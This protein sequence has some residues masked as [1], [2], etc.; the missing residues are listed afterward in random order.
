MKYHEARI[1]LL[2]AL[3]RLRDKTCDAAFT[4]R[5][6]AL[7]Y[8][9]ANNM[10][11]SFVDEGEPMLH[12]LRKRVRDTPDLAGIQQTI[13]DRLLAA[14]EEQWIPASEDQSRT[15]RDLLRYREIEILGHIAHGLST[16]KQ[17]LPQRTNSST[18]C[19]NEAWEMRLLVS[20]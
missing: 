10:I 2:C 5:E 17:P 14:F 4:A 1:S 18:R 19:L 7:R 12:L 16:L 8:A 20:Q 9:Q 6:D 11:G 3:A 13:L 15:A